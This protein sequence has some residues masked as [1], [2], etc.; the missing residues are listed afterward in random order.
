MNTTTVAPD[1][2]DTYDMVVVHNTFRRHFRALPDLVTAVAAG[3]VDRA[4]RLVE[5]LDE[6]GNGLHQHHTGEDELMWPLL[7]ERAPA[8]AALV[9]RM[10]EQHERIAELTERAHREAAEFAAAADPSARDR[11]AATL[12]A[13]AVALDEHMAE[14]ERHVLPVVENVMTATEW[15]ALGERG[16]EHMP[17]DRQLVFLGFILQGV[18]DTD[19]RKFLAEMPL[20]AR[21]AWRL[22]GRR[23]F[24]KEYRAIYRT[25]P[26]W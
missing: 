5:F 19:R 18:S 8:D 20:P 22:L 15:Q 7:L 6:L 26:E 11:L 4:G 23:A 25:D 14:E 13:L 21:L 16:R 17:K 1:R 24:A 3:D 10:E 2:P 9:L 12:T